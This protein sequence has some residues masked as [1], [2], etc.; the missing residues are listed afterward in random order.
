MGELKYKDDI[1]K[2]GDA[3]GELTQR[4]YD[5]LTGIQ[6]GKIPDRFGWVCE[7]ED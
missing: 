7:L 4:L 6:L 5:E 3:I 1:I 2:I